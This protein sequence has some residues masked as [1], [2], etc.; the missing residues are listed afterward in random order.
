MVAF[1]LMGSHTV[2][3]VIP[4]LSFGDSHVPGK[5]SQVRMEEDWASFP[6]LSFY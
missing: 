5:P 6:S 4:G 1:Y 2:A 3:M